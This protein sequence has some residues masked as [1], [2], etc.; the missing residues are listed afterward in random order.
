MRVWPQ[1]KKSSRSVSFTEGEFIN[2]VCV[3]SPP[4]VFF[5]Q[6]IRKTKY[7]GSEWWYSSLESLI[8]NQNKP[9]SLL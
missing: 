9:L 3:H 7:S 8:L 2:I 4:T 5:S 6:P 1:K